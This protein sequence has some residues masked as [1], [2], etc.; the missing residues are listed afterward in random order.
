MAVTQ[1]KIYFA[2]ENKT[3]IVDITPTTTAEDI[4]IKLCKK[5]CIGTVARH[6][7]GL[8]THGKQIFLM[9]SATFTEK[10]REFDLRIRF[11][12]TSIE[13]LK[14]ID[15]NAYDYFFHQAR[16][17]VLENKIPDLIFDNYRKELVG[18][19]I[20]DMYRVM[21]ENDVSRETIEGDYKKYIPKAVLSRHHFFVKKPIREGLN[22]IKKSLQD[23]WYVKEQYLKQ[24][25]R[26]VPEYLAEEYKVMMDD[27]ESIIEVIIKTSQHAE[28]PGINYTSLSK[29]DKWHNICSLED[30]AFISIRDNTVELSRKNG[31]PIYLFFKKEPEMYSFVSYVDG[32][33]RLSVKWTFNLCRNV[34][35]PSLEKLYAMRCHGPV[36][37]EFSYAKLEEKR[38][39]QPGCYII[40]ESESKYNIYYVD[41]CLKNSSK[42]KTFK[43]ERLGS[44]EFVFHDDLTKYPSIPAIVAAYKN[45]NDAIY[46]KECLPPS[47]TDKSPLL[48]CAKEDLSSDIVTEASSMI[49]KDPVFISTQNILVFKADKKQNED[50]VT[51]IYRCM[52]KHA[53]GK[54]IEV[55]MKT[56]KK[57]HR[58]KH[59]KDMLEA[60]GQWSLVQSSSI[61]RLFGV[62][63]SG[64]LSMILE[65]IKYGPL[66]EYLRQNK[67]KLKEV[68]LIEASSALAN[69][70][71]HLEDIGIVHGKIRCKKLLVCN[72]DSREFKVK[73]GLPSIKTSYEKEELHWI[74]IECYGKEDLAKTS[75]AA[76]VWAYGTT[77]W[78][79]FSYGQKIKSIELNQMRMWY[80][81]GKRLPKPNTCSEDIYE[82]MLSCWEKDPHH[83]KKPQSIVRDISHLMYQVYGSRRVHN[84][85]QVKPPHRGITTSTS[86]LASASTVAMDELC[87]AESMSELN[88][89]VL[90][91]PNMNM[92]RREWHSVENMITFDTL[93][94][95]GFSSFLNNFTT[96][97][98]LTSGVPSMQSI[99]ELDCNYN[100]ILQGRI[101][102]GFYGEVYKGLL[103]RNY[104]SKTG[105]IL[106]AVKKLKKTAVSS[107]RQDFERE[108]EIMKALRHPNIV[109]I[110]GVKNDDETLLVME[111]IPHGSLQCYVK[112]H[113]EHLSTKQLL[114]YSLGIAKGM[115][116][117]GQRN[118]VHRDL[119]ARNILVVDENDVKISDF[120]L[121]QFINAGDYYVLQTN[122]DLPIKWYAPES[123]N[124]GK[125]STKSDVWSYGVTLWEMF[126]YGEEPK[127]ADESKSG[128]PEQQQILKL[129]QDGIR[130][131]CLT[132]FPRLTY[133]R[134]I[135][136]CW[137]Y[138]PKE[139]P[140]FTTI[141]KNIEYEIQNET[142]L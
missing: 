96:S 88:Q 103:E 121:A 47:E 139:R 131:P 30:I 142:D 73:L 70:L 136:P 141:C 85:A 105:P 90:S 102:Q 11:K 101:G 83:R 51:L 13:K 115:E 134:V 69:A 45:E 59:L 80:N 55:A 111:Y 94:S 135:H 16:L 133:I 95:D 140:T 32:Y 19:G 3:E 108:I 127:L 114:L 84:Y 99:F 52:W 6:L 68:D 37:G 75:P 60:A 64:Y 44:N 12:V 26:M 53:K 33:Y 78:E 56:L 79:I 138:T 25:D 109:E 98:T 91:T 71:W 35:T 116:Y 74:P 40:R 9:P 39:N 92:A 130:Y 62:T 137:A 8:R 119:A 112:I 125:F 43:L 76:D 38:N 100:V 18:L 97:T 123:L 122:R 77:L 81:T 20:A 41:V 117:L 34:I 132:Q 5:L 17:D 21:L 120:G 128:E 118:I 58:D 89:D 106:V 31:I 49:L 7:F 110:L 22:N 61:V 54:K 2:I 67:N 27:R 4:C 87:K 113:K 66:D 124:E 82:L 93:S 50:G 10:T 15:I 36:G 42:P 65:Y 107:S 24:L 126:S 104:D 63:V 29:N 23:A 28:E 86:S 46:L 57:E 129:L 1:L 72:H 48:L 14:K